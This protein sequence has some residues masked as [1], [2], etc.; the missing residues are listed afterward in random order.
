MPA[1]TTTMRQV[2]EIL[3]LKLVGG[4]PTR[5]IARR[6]GV[7]ASTV[8]TTKQPCLICGR[9]P[10]DAHHLRF[11]QSQALGRK[12]AMNSPSRCAGVTIARCTA[13]G[14]RPSRPV[15]FGCR[16]I[17]CRSSRTKRQ[18]KMPLPRTLLRK[19]AT[20]IDRAAGGARIAKRSRL[21]RLARN[22]LLQADRGQPA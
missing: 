2:R 16:R 12:S 7:V 14:I 22:D 20:V 3:R 15:R 9:R 11:A 4:I 21:P 18:S 8:R 17:R 6:V 13:A 10:S 1:E 5:E 19:R